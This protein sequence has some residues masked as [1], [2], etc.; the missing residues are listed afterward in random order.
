M[1][2]A[3]RR[4]IEQLILQSRCPV[5]VLEAALLVECGYRGLCD[6]FWFVRTSA[7]V[8]RERLKQTRNY[9]DEKIDALMKNQLSDEEF[10]KNSDRVIENNSTV[11]ALEKEIAAAMHH[12][13][14]Q[15]E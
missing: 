3:V 12:L 4:R 6:E 14:A 1:H 13:Y 7:R 8:R 5:V 2:P 15:P 9:S 11:E 10:I